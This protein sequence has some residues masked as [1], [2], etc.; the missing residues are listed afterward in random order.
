MTADRLLKIKRGH[1]A[2]E[3]QLHWQLDGLF[4]EDDAR[5]LIDNAAEVLNILHKLALQLMKQEASPKASMHAKRLRCGY[6]VF[7]AIK[8]LRVNGFS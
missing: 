5:A 1:W 3:N 4:R 2:I 8:V 7:Y 6:D